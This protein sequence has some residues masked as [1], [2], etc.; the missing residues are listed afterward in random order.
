[1]NNKGKSFLE[2]KLFLAIG[3]L[4]L[5]LILNIGLFFAIYEFSLI[6]HNSDLVVFSWRMFVV[7]FF[8]PLVFYFCTSMFFYVIF[9]RLPK[10]FNL[11][12]KYLVIFGVLCFLFSLPL[13]WYGDLKLKEN[14]YFTCYKKSVSAPQKYAKNKKL[15]D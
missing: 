4:F 6:Y 10:Y 5:F 12:L 1:M 9:S 15:C 14:G 11:F 3:M 2:S 7:L 13:Y 8:Y